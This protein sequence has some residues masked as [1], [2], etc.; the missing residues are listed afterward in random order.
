MPNGNSETEVRVRSE[1]PR[2]RVAIF[3]R[4][5]LRIMEALTTEVAFAK[6]LK[7]SEGVRYIDI[8]E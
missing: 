1:V 4:Q 5:R 2:G 8:W 7:R 6:R 3:N